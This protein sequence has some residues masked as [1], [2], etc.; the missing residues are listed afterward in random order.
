MRDAGAH[1]GYLRDRMNAQRG[2]CEPGIDIEAAIDEAAADI[3]SREALAFVALLQRGFYRRR[4]EILQARA[5][6]QQACD[7]GSMPDFLLGTAH[8]RADS[9]WRVASSDVFGVP[10]RVAL[11]GPA[12]PDPIGA[13][14]ASG[15]DIFIADFEDAMTPSWAN[16]VAGQVNIRNAVASRGEKPAGFASLA[17]ALAVR[18]RSW[19]RQEQHVRI[20]GKPC[21]AAIFD[22]ALFV[23]HNAA[24]LLAYGGCLR[25]YLAKLESHLE[26]RL[27]NDI[28]CLA[29]D[30]LRIP[31]GT[32]KAVC[33]IE[34][35]GAA[36]EID[37]IVYEL[38]DHSAG[39]HAGG[40]SYI[41]SALRALRARRD[42]DLAGGF[43]PDSELPCVRGLQ[44]LVAQTCRRRGTFGTS[45]TPT[46]IPIVSDPA[47]NEAALTPMAGKAG[48]L[49]TDGFDGARVTHPG[50]VKIARAAFARSIDASVIGA[51]IAQ[52]QAPTIEALL[53]VG[54]PSPVAAGVLRR[55]CEF[56]IRY[57]D[58]W[59][60]GRGSAPIFNRVTDA[61]TFDC[62]YALTWHLQRSAVAVMADGRKV[63]RELI[64]KAI[65][66]ALKTILAAP[67]DSFISDA[68]WA[69]AAGLFEHVCNDDHLESLIAFP[70]TH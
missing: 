27:W 52:G 56:A 28:F 10:C 45:E 33:D 48:Q 2:A 21:A 17:P 7:Q 3:L 18:P 62:V 55:N 30:E 29:Q 23:F 58:N 59:L 19:P 49:V 68:R 36:L 60:A 65:A 5:R 34:T 20:D 40:R 64:R 42:L 67:R 41:Y 13:G 15:A 35:L 32:L 6:C 9:D 66:A 47:A 54:P 31:R 11:I 44:R 50:Q 53:D 70:G 1:T 46:N 69:R 38:R 12:G 37:E 26:A 16:V 14:L 51:G 4:A 63:D 24:P 61:S 57:L 39:L 43:T 8:I 22:F 25:V